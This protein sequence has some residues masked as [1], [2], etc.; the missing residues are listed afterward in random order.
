[1]LPK[2]I[3]LREERE[4]GF[5]LI[6]LLVVILIIGILSAIAIPAFLNQ[7]K[8]AVDSSVQS[9]V[10]NAAKQV[11]TWAVKQGTGAVYIPRTGTA[12]EKAAAGPI[13]E[14]KLSQGT[15]MTIS[16]SSFHYV[17]EAYNEGGD[18][19]KKQGSGAT[20]TGGYFYDSQAGGMVKTKPAVPTAATAGIAAGTAQL[21]NK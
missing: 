20:Q 21:S 13:G 11:E 3:Q 6:E 8:S 16:G 9:D 1:M 5:T 14:I 10:S 15:E 17:I 7:R 4:E 2:L 19:A 18:V 12:A